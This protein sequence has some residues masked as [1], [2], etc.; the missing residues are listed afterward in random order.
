MTPT[1]DRHRTHESTAGLLATTAGVVVGLVAVYAA[2]PLS[3]RNQAW[4]VLL[5]LGAMTAV[6]P[7]LVHRLRGILQAENPFAAAVAAV[8]VT[9]TLVILGSASMYFGMASSDPGQ[10]RGLET[11]IDAVYFAVVIMSTIGFGDITPVGQAARLVTTLHIV[12]TLTFA[13]GAIRLVTWAGRRR[14]DRG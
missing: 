4:G 8:A 5:G 7:I 6:I 3:G 13:G 1:A 12:V 14:L 9:F 2:A 11:K 10:F